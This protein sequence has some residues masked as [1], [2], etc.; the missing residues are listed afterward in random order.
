MQLRGISRDTFKQY[1]KLTYVYQCQ[2]CEQKYTH[3]GY[4]NKHMKFVHGGKTYQCQYCEYK[5]SRNDYL[6]KHNQS[7]H[8]GK[9][10]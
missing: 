10:F 9:T 1:M 8:E 6:K 5:T 2:H 3:K 7:I 4:L